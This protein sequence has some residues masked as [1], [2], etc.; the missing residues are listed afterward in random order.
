M[1]GL[2]QQRQPL[3]AIVLNACLVNGRLIMRLTS[4]MHNVG[5]GGKCKSA[6]DS[7]NDLLRGSYAESMVGLQP[8]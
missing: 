5:E 3:F 4:G 8:P 2:D 7:F 6:T 1:A